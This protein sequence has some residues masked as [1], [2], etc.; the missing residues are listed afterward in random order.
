[1]YVWQNKM[2][3]NSILLVVLTYT[4]FFMTEYQ[5]IK[6]KSFWKVKSK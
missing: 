2:D 4:A 5:R 3:K 1:M 6:L